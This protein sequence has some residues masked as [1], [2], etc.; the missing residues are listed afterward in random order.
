MSDLAPVTH[1]DG[2]LTGKEDRSDA[3]YLSGR[4]DLDK[5]LAFEHLPVLILEE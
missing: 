2:H 5:T 3:I 1:Q 4:L